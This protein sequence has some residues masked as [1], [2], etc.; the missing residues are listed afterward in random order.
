MN[1][2]EFIQAFEE[3]L[4]LP[5]GQVKPDTLLSSIARYDSM[6]RLSVMAMADTKLGAVLDAD[7]MQR[8]RTVADLHA[9]AQHRVS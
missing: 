7:A 1:I 9:L 8:C 2:Q 5:G 4:E 6:G 3:A